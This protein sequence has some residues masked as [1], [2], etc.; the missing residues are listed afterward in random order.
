MTLISE[1]VKLLKQAEIVF[2]IVTP[3]S[4][5]AKEFI[6]VQNNDGLVISFNVSTKPTFAALVTLVLNQI[7]ILNLKITEGFYVNYEGFKFIGENADKEY[8]R[9]ITSTIAKEIKRVI[10]FE[11]RND[12]I[13]SNDK[14]F[15]T[16]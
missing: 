13:M 8:R 12:A 9:D 15:Y 7:K 16:A 3:I 5:R 4:I 11:K 10:E 14:I 1:A 6:I 2:S